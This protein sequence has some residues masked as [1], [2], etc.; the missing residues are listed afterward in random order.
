MYGWGTILSER[1]NWQRF[2]STIGLVCVPVE[3]PTL[4]KAVGIRSRQDVI[5]TICQV[6]VDIFHP[7]VELIF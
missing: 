7:K 3:K 1:K 5:Q 6:R 4:Q 2:C